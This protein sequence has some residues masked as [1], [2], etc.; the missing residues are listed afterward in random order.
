ME[1][2]SIQLYSTAQEKVTNPAS[3]TFLK[4]LV[5]EE[6]RHRTNLLQ[7]MEDPGKI[8][9]IGTL[10]TVVQ[11]LKIVDTLKDATLSP[12][13]DYQDILIYAAK[14]EK[15]THDFYIE[16]AM[17]YKESQIGKMFVNLAQEELRH[18]YRLETE[19]DDIVLKWM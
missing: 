7:A 15:V 19:Y 18:K 9:E 6:G 11:D 1:E 14:R 10:D 3:R 8:Q 2:Q 12:D 17:K 5:T 13:A 16:M 4:E